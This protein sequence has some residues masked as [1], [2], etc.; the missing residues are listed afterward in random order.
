MQD[1]P[2]RQPSQPLRRVFG[3]LPANWLGN[4]KPPRPIEA[5]SGGLKV[6]ALLVGTIDPIESTTP[7]VEPCPGDCDANGDVTIAE[8][9]VALNIAL[10]RL[11]F[12]TCRAGFECGR[13]SSCVSISHLTTAVIRALDGCSENAR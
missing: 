4:G 3:N 9:V 10:D 13:G 6:D 8:L 5:P 1:D 2:R 12:A 11:P 7:P